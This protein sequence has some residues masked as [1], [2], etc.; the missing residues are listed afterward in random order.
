MTPWNSFRFIDVGRQKYE[1]I[2]KYEVRA[3]AA[4]HGHGTARRREPFK[5]PPQDS[6]SASTLSTPRANRPRRSRTGNSQHGRRPLRVERTVEEVDQV[7]MLLTPYSKPASLA[8]QGWVDDMVN[9][10][11]YT[12]RLHTYFQ[13]AFHVLT[14]SRGFNNQFAKVWPPLNLEMKLGFA[15]SYVVNWYQVHA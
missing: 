11:E 1:T 4:F 15:P 7:P 2:I 13:K 10:C 6:R 8:N 3:Q 5:Y 12:G 9:E 14:Y